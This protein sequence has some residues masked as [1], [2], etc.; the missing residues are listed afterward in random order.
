MF[1]DAFE[2]SE[3]ETADAAE[4][5]SGTGEVRSGGEGKT[6]KP[7]KPSPFEARLQKMDKKIQALTDALAATM[8]KKDRAKLL[9]N[10]AEF[11]E[12]EPSMEGE[13]SSRVAPDDSLSARSDRRGFNSLMLDFKEEH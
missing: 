7:A 5:P 6:K 10:L 11:D 12:A 2:D 4:G 1:G 3:E 13:M 9:A 8:N